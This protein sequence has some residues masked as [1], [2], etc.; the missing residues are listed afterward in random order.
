MQWFRQVRT[1]ALLSLLLC[2]TAGAQ[3]AATVPP[4]SDIYRI[5]EEVS[6]FFPVPVHLGLRPASQT[7]LRQALDRL[8]GAVDS[9]PEAHPRRAWALRRLETVREVAGLD[10]ATRARGAIATDIFGSDGREEPIASN[11]LGSLDATEHSFAR[12]RTGLPAPSGTAWAVIPTGT[13]GSSR[14]AVVA[15]PSFVA[16]ADGTPRGI[17]VIRRLYGRAVIRNV[18]M[19]LGS[20]ERRWGQSAFGPLFL[21]SNAAPVPAVSLGT[22]TSIVLPWWFRLAGPVQAT[23]LVGD[24]GPTQTPPHARLAGWQVNIQPWSRFE[25]GVAVLAQT[26]G[27][28]APPA[29]F[30]ERLVDLFPAIDALAPQHADLQ[31]SNK[32]AGGNLR[33]RFPELSGLDVYYELAIDD[34]DGRRLVS[35]LVDDA[36]HLLGARIAAGPVVWRAEWHRTAIRLYEHTQFPSGFTFRRH[37]LGSPL[38]PH[39]AA[40]YLSAAGE[41]GGGMRTELVVGDERRDPAQYTVTVSGERDRGFQ[42]IRVTDEPDV[43][44]RFAIGSV[45]RRLGT[46]AIRLTTGYARVWRTGLPARHE[47]LL[48]LS[49]RSHALPTF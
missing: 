45:D 22:D 12:T 17:V 7:A 9:A 47:W 39:A 6:A 8:R 10:T 2:G 49:L 40:G 29:T 41:V 1:A 26:G 20:D 43:R 4:S 3:G 44:R 15:E 34:F 14:F 46:G 31:F 33:L 25:L 28:G 24:L 42:F 18:A 37:L 13:A 27:N 5:L 32:I 11:G 19:Q 16:V 21:S 30:L 35:S 23:I 38:G 36:G 48:Q